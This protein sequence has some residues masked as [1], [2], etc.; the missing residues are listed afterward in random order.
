MKQP[1]IKTPEQIQNITDSCKYLTE[2]LYYLREHTKAGMKLIEVEQLSQEWLDQR[3]LKGA[4]KNYDGFPAN[5]C[6]SVNDC[7]VHGIPDDTIL[8][9]W[10]LLKIDAGIIYKK[11]YSDAAISMII[12]DEGLNPLGADLIRATKEAL[13]LGVDAIEVGKE[14]YW[15]SKA[16]YNHIRNSWFSIIKTLCGHGVWNAVHEKPL[17]YNYPNAE[18]KKI[19]LQPGMVIAIE[20]ITAIASDDVVFSDLNDWNLY[21]KKGDLWA[22]WEYTILITE[23]WPKILA[24]ITEDF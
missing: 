8:A 14:A 1:S 7:V 12:W 3:N 19:V 11:G 21:C 24:G 5:L 20:P 6:L 9:N 4:F 2:M 13:D 23:N 10:D 22:Q 17:F 16:I 15:I 18:M